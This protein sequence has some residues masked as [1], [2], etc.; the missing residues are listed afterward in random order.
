MMNFKV[1]IGFFWVAVLAAVPAAAQYYNGSTTGNGPGTLRRNPLNT[2]ERGTAQ[3]RTI[4]TDGFGNQR[5]ADFVEIE[6]V[7]IPFVPTPTGNV[8]FLSSFVTAPTGD[9]Y[10]IDWK[11]ASVLI[12]AAGGGG[13][14]ADKD[15]LKISNNQVP[16][17]I[18]DSIYTDNYAAI[19]LRRVWPDAQLLLGDSSALAGGN[20]VILGNREGRLGFYRLTG[21][22][23]SSIGQEGAT[24]TARLGTGATNFVVQ[25]AAG[26]GPTA[27][28]A[29]FN[30]LFELS[31]P[32][33]YA[34]F[35]QYPNTRNDAGTATN[36]LFTDSQGVLQSQPT[37]V[38][39]PGFGEYVDDA[40]AAT[41]GVPINGLYYLATG[42]PY[43]MPSGTPKKRKV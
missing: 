11:G 21:P 7:A 23:W 37:T 32:L 18:T 6:T 39:V 13:A 41:N 12:R 28:V 42:N 14:V 38:L 15:W 8:A 19:N 17:A 5:W 9:I 10:Y 35:H 2:L 29:P 1:V 4:L 31:S 16:Q 36:F 40:A 24:L 43:G 30:N 27:A 22:L 3:G 26:T 25:T 33:N 34:R 20:A